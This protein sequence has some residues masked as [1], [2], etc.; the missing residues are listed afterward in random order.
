MATDGA[1][2]CMEFG[3]S[4][5]E[6]L[7]NFSATMNDSQISRISFAGTSIINQFPSIRCHPGHIQQEAISKSRKIIF[8]RI[9]S[10]VSFGTNFPSAYYSLREKGDNS[11]SLMLLNLHSGMQCL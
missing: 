5:E 1:M 2:R 9:F 4:L 6:H 3:A 7:C 10:Q 8:Y 11:Q